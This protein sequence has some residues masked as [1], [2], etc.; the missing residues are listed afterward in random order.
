MSPAC[1]YRHC[2]PQLLPNSRQKLYPH[3]LRQHPRPELPLPCPQR[4]PFRKRPPSHRP[5]PRHRRNTPVTRARQGSGCRLDRRSWVIVFSV[6]PKQLSNGLFSGVFDP[7]FSF[8]ANAT[9]TVFGNASVTVFFFGSTVAFFSS[10]LRRWSSSLMCLSSPISLPHVRHLLGTR[11]P[12]PRQPL[13]F[14]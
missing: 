1:R 2:L 3:P 7:A 6:I 10:A 5:P 13:Y 4:H 9:A 12:H 11:L 14:R 8:R